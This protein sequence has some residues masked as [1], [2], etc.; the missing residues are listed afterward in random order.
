MVGAAAVV[1]RERIREEW[2]IH[3]LSSE[4]RRARI[5]AIWKLSE[6]HSTKSIPPLLALVRAPETP[7][8]SDLIDR[9]AF[10][11]KEPCS[12]MADVAMR[13]LLAL[14]SPGIAALSEEPHAWPLLSRLIEA[15]DAN[16]EET[17]APAAA[18]ALILGEDGRLERLRPL[19]SRPKLLKETFA[20]SRH[21]LRGC[22]SHGCRKLESEDFLER[23]Q[24][25]FLLGFLGPLARD[26]VPALEKALRD[27]HELVRLAARDALA[28]IGPSRA[29]PQGRS[30]G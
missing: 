1:G 15:Q 13:A 18:E 27:D 12:S 11:R 5:E 19:A 21:L 26:A 22:I 8:S 17:L 3:R 9:A 10:R 4:D 20:R 28:L 2:Y 25:A 23:S 24:A 14:G 6:L 30:S 29:A 7:L 16:D